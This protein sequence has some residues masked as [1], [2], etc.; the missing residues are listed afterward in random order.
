MGMNQEAGGARFI[1][2]KSMGPSVMQGDKS[3]NPCVNSLGVERQGT[4]GK[5]KGRM[6]GSLNAK[7]ELG[8]LREW[9][10]QLRSEID[11]GLVR[12]DVVLQ[13]MEGDGPGQLKNK[14]I[15]ISKP[16]PKSKKRFRFKEKRLNFFG[17]KVNAGT[18]P[19]AQLDGAG[20]SAG[21]LVG[22]SKPIVIP[23]ELRSLAGRGSLEGLPQK[24]NSL[25]QLGGEKATSL[26]A[27]EGKDRN[28]GHLGGLGSMEGTNHSGGEGIPSSGSDD[29][30]PVISEPIP[31]ADRSL[32]GKRREAGSVQRPLMGGSANS[33]PQR[34]PPAAPVSGS[35]AIRGDRGSVSRPECSW[36]AG[37]TGFG[38]VHTGE[39]VGSSDLVAIS[40]KEAAIQARVVSVQN[41]SGTI[42]E[43][44]VEAN[45]GGEEKLAQVCSLETTTALE[46]YRR[47]DTP[48]QV[49]HRDSGD[50]KEGDMAES[51]LQGG[52]Y[53]QGVGQS[54][55]ENTFVECSLEKSLEVSDVAGLSWDGQEGRKEEHLRRIIAD[56][57][58]IG[59]DGDNNISY[60]QQTANSMGRFWGNCS[61]DE[62]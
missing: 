23:E 10:W 51:S 46:V 4:Q 60:F 16:K 43:S 21:L 40:E 58:E 28:M 38:P 22:L 30:I 19:L 6:E 11:A 1:R 44:G 61:D 17:K 56:K 39:V 36:V 34:M 32:E 25:L 29:I 24:P 13:K 20:P 14:K 5:V 9:L 53:E 42:V 8:G 48:P 47:R 12:V 57:T 55:A 2:R 45:P 31:A 37:R 41:E 50:S 54:S 26:G 7:Q 62:A 3:C 27:T 33:E 18:S 15:W 49:R 35:G 52:V 59:R